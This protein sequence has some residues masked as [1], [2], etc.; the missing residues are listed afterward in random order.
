MQRA[1]DRPPQHD[2]HEAAAGAEAIEQSA[3]NDVQRGIGEQERGLQIGEL[4]V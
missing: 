1:G 3:A 2:E 4:L